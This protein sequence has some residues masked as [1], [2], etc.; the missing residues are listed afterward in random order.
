MF[1]EK[2]EEERDAIECVS[3]HREYDYLPYFNFESF[4]V[5]LLVYFATS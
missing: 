1:V 5:R 2:V 3:M 4:L